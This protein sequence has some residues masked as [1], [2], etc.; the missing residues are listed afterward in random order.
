MLRIVIAEDDR[1][2]A[3]TVQHFCREKFRPEPVSI[4][5]FETVTPALYYVQENPVDL[6][7]LDI[8]LHGESG[9]GL[10]KEP[11]EQKTFYTI[12]VSSDTGNAV[13]AFSYGVVDFVAKPFSRERFMTALSRMQQISRGADIQKNSL[14]IKRDG[15]LHLLRFR[16]ILYL[17]SDANFTDIFLRNGKVERIRRTLDSMM[18]D[19]NSDF[20]RAHRSCI[21]NLSEIT[22]VV[23]TKNNTFKI[24]IDDR[25]E[26]PC[27]RSRYEVLRNVLMGP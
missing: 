11:F 26:L 21:V 27:S 16:D 25:F 5:C 12:I 19:L 17:E 24:V 2:T 15:Q 8:N 10:L 3:R 18:E 13:D 23:R 9:F 7:V 14:P 6:L 4:T 22:R 1:L 20:F